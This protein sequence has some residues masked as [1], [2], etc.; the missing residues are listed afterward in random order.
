MFHET[1]YSDSKNEREE[2]R[3]KFDILILK[4]MYSF[5]QEELGATENQSYQDLAGIL[6]SLKEIGAS[7][8]EKLEIMSENNQA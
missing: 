2:C 3:D 7:T 4:Y 5:F 6:Q 8:K 1:N